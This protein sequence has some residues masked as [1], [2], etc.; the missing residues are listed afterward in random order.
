MTFDMVVVLFTYQAVPIGTASRAWV[1][2]LGSIDRFAAIYPSSILHYDTLLRCRVVSCRV[3]CL[4]TLSGSSGMSIQPCLPHR[5]T[6]NGTWADWNV[7]ATSSRGR[8]GTCTGASYRSDSQTSLPWH[9]ATISPVV[10][11]IWYGC[12]A[13]CAVLT[14]R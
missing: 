13:A 7:D 12:L 9:E 10:S 2:G 3:V 4:S 5:R 11:I 14:Y 6:W 8:G 1:G